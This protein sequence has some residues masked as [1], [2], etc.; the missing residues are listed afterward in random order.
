MLMANLKHYGPDN[1]SKRLPLSL[2]C[3]VALSQWG[4]YL[5]GF[6]APELRLPAATV[7]GL[8]TSFAVHLKRSSDAIPLAHCIAFMGVVC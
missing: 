6:P 3:H 8:A 2:L 7:C 4:G 1:T 5:C